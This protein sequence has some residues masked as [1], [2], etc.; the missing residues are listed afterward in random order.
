MKTEKGESIDFIFTDPPFGGNINYSEMNRLWEAWLG[1]FTDTSNEAIVNRVQ[2]KS[3]SD[4][5]GLMKRSLSECYRVLRPGH[6][7]LLVF[8]NS[9]RNI[10]DALRKAVHKAGF[11]IERLD[12]FDK[13]HG[14][15]KQFVSKNTAGFDLVLHCRKP[16]SSKLANAKANEVTN[17]ESITLF[18]ARRNGDIPVTGFLHVVRENEPDLRRLYS[19]WLTYAFPKNHELVDFSTFCVL[20][21]QISRAPLK[22]RGTLYTAIS[23]SYN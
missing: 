14:T 18:M 3:V 16:L 21:E 5:E 8:M 13:Q 22:I 9:S 19:E 11:I 2:G 12:I 4:Y 6:W 10:W 20:V 15:F 17:E 1:E 23:K 7:M